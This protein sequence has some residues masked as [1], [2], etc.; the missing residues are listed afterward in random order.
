MDAIDEL[1]QLADSTHQA[2]AL[3]ADEDVDKNSSSSRRPS[4]FLNVVALNNTENG[5][6]VGPSTFLDVLSLVGLLGCCYGYLACARCSSSG[7]LVL[8]EPVSTVKGG[9]QHL[10]PPK[11]ERCSNCSGSGKVNHALGF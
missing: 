1:A 11:T 7:V 8:V 9:D 3:L 2:S 10:A 5:S 4:T 6:S